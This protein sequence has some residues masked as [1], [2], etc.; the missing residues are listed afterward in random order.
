MEKN[1]SI[2]YSSSLVMAKNWFIEKIPVFFRQ[3]I[4]YEGSLD[5]TVSNND[6]INDKISQKRFKKVRPIISYF[7][8][9]L[10]K[11]TTI[12]EMP[13]Q[14]IKFLV[15]FFK[16]GAP[17]DPTSITLFERDR[18]SVDE[19]N[20]YYDMDQKSKDFLRIYFL[21]G[22]ALIFLTMLDEDAF[23]NVKVNTKN[24]KVIAGVLYH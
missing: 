24:L 7:F 9:R 3:I 19:F 23:S 16:H 5:F 21:F 2:V 1:I 18:I 14:M 6:Y 12:K 22:K 11:I 10:L 20:T 15:D 13:Q 8:K 17:V 4:N